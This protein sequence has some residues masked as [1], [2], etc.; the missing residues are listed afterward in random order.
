VLCC[1]YLA[2]YYQAREEGIDF[3]VM[4]TRGQSATVQLLVGSVAEYTVHHADVPVV[5]VR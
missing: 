3:I 2:I 4:G 1:I 5:V